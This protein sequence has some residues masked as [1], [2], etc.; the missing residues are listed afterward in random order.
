MDL[1]SSS[2]THPPSSPS[3]EDLTFS[4]YGS[5]LELFFGCPPWN[6]PLCEIGTRHCTPCIEY[7]PYNVSQGS[8]VDGML[9]GACDK[10]L[11]YIG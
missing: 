3:R 1:T 2:L 6:V 8:P 9:P 5:V 10:M 11:S 4:E 7:K